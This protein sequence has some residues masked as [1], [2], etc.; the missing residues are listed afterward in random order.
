MRR[1][2]PL[3]LFSLFAC[4]SSPP[5]QAQA[6]EPV[7]ISPP[8]SKQSPQPQPK[9]P[10]APAAAPET[11]PPDPNQ[12]QGG[13]KQ[14]HPAGASGEARPAAAR[15]GRPLGSPCDPADTNHCGKSG[16]V[17]V[18]RDESHSMALH[19]N[20][21]CTLNK[22]TAQT[23]YVFAACV[24]EGQI[25]ASGRCVMCRM[26]DAGWSVVG[27]INEMTSAQ[28]LDLQQR[29]GLPA[30][31]ALQSEAAWKAALSIA[32]SKVKP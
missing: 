15:A 25:H 8:V 7:V 1:L 3:S 26:I 27:Q 10:S 2:L 23:G 28:T 20:M 17:A 4:G 31:P 5:Q 19:S 29:L 30:K 13:L 21:P 24:A 22:V 18:Q 6:A 14:P 11:T 9:D 16:R 32:A 12:P